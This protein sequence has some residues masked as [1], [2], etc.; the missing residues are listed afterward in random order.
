VKEGRK[1]VKR[2]KESE[3]REKDRYWGREEGERV[4]D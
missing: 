1:E 3:K 2:E 4:R